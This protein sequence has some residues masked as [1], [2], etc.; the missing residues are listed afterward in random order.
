MIQRRQKHYIIQEPDE[1]LH[2]VMA[3][4]VPQGIVKALSKVLPDKSI[5]YKIFMEKEGQQIELLAEG[6][7]SLEDYNKV[8][9]KFEQEMLLPH[10]N[11]WQEIKPEIIVRE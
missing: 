7:S 6:V 4:D 1:E 11:R 2:Q 9:E 5:A 8:T 10:G 3:G